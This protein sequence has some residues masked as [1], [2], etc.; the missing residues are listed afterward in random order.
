MSLICWLDVL[1]VL[2]IAMINERKNNRN[3]NFTKLF[4]TFIVNAQKNIKMGRNN[5]E[6]YTGCHNK[7]LEWNLN[8]T[9]IYI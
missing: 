1:L 9:L 3:Y 8:F 7:N 6:E 5:I 4:V 2:K